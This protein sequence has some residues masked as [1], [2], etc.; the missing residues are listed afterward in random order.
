MTI[1][2][3]GWPHRWAASDRPPPTIDDIVE[4]VVSARLGMFS[5]DRIVEAQR[6]IVALADGLAEALEWME[7]QARLRLSATEWW[8]ERVAI[9][10]V[11]VI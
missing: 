3:D 1:K 11:Q 4:G 7:E 5:P 9:G 2:D 8:I 6:L 10:P